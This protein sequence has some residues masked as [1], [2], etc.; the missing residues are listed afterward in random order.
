MGSRHLHYFMRDHE[1]DL[2]HKIGNISNSGFI[3]SYCLIILQS[4]WHKLY[5]NYIIFKKDKT[6]RLLRTRKG[7]VSSDNIEIF[8]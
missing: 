7:N 2:W 3:A 5:S 8:N 1:V 6:I 4:M